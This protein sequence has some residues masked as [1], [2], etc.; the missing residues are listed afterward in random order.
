MQ[1]KIDKERI[2]K[3]LE[4]NNKWWKKRDF[5]LDFKPREIYPKI[6]RF[7]EGK[8][9][10]AL[11]G[12]RRVGKTTIMFKL[13]KDFIQGYGNK[14]IVYF[15]FDEFKEARLEEILEVYLDLFDKEIEDGKYLVLFDEIQKVED[16]EEQLKRL[17][18]ENQNIKFVI[19]GSESLF[20]EKSSKESLAGRI[21]DFKIRQLSFKEYLRFRGKEFDNLKLYKKEILSEFKKYLFSNGFPELIGK[22]KE[23]IEKYL[24]GTIIER[25]I[26]RDAPQVFKIREPEI[27]EQILRI[28]LKDPGRMINFNGLA[29]QLQ[30]SRQTIS[31][32]LNY[33]EKSFL[34][35]KVYNYSGSQRK[36]E[37]KMKKYYPAILL[38]ETIKNYFGKAFETAI[39]L[40][41]EADYFWR[42]QYKNEVDTI[43]I[44]RDDL[45]PIEIK[46][47]E[48]SE[49]D[50]KPLKLFSKKFD[51]EKPTVITYDKKI[52]MEG[53]EVIPFY[54]YF[55]RK[56]KKEIKEK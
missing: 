8:Q 40:D 50:L 24:R 6:K 52:K 19:S 3:I 12:L 25:I 36:T 11:N 30:I 5:E 22:D 51:T 42:D 34:I 33:L 56:D 45:F 41:L 7:M 31:N 10:L 37:R 13:A 15:S 4:K 2:R 21:F 28:I 38:P 47:G 14:N 44:E 17:Y 1:N 53:I 32:Y 29:G 18:D 20:I 16:W 54:E 35:K 26:Y 46:P 23:V 39:I 49:K 43:K 48:F 55:L 9:I 27:L